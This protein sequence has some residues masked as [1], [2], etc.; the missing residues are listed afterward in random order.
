MGS[1]KQNNNFYLFL[2]LRIHIII[3]HND[4]SVTLS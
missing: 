3:V 1:R 4:M 2:L